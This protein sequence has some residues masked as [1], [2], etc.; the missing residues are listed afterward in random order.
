MRPLGAAYAV[1]LAG[2]GEAGAAVLG[3]AIRVE[4]HAVDPAA[5]R[6]GGVQG[7]DDQLGA[8]MRLD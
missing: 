4:D 3:A 2:G 6:H 8:H 7:V 1:L 5:G